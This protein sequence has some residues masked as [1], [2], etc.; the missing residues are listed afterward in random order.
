MNSIRKHIA[1]DKTLFGKTIPE[2]HKTLDKD[3]DRLGGHHRVLTHS[4]DTL[5][6]ISQRYGAFGY[7]LALIHLGLD[8]GLLDK[9]LFFEQIECPICKKVFDNKRGLKIHIKKKHEKC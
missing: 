3:E 4:L 1:V 8:Y 9:S 2:V 5:E 7:L 6:R